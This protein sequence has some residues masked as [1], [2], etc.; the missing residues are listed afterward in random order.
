MPTIKPLDEQAIIQAAT[1][2]GAIITAEEHLEH[3]GLGSGIAHVVARYNPVPL[4]FVAI[5]NGYA[6]S[7]KPEELIDR[8][9]LTAADIEQAV[10]STMLRKG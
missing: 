10:Q 6:K 7:G 5:K 4:A 2:T 8:C 1:E 3:G 9:G